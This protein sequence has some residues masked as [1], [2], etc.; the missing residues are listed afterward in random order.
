MKSVWVRLGA[1]IV[2]G[3]F[4]AATA[5]AQP[6]EREGVKLEP[7]VQVGSAALQLNGAGVRTR[8]IFKVYVAGLYV[9]QKSNSPAALLSQKGPRRM[10]LTM[11]R[12]LS[13]DSFADAMNDGLKNNHTEAQLVGFK[14]QI[15]ALNAALKAVD[16]VKKGDA[17]NI[18]YTAETGTRIT[19]NGQAKGA[20]IPGE[21][22]Y[23]AILRIWLGEKPAD[24]DLKKGLLGG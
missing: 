15:D 4:A 21:D 18:E 9:P 22:F 24:G 11:L 12:N 2:V 6:V 23:N 7:T 3:T 16:E 14:P 1:A 8:A 13:A 20:A 19:V 5:H 17:V 10:A